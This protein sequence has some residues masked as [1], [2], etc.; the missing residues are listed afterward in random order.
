VVLDRDLNA[1]LNMLRVGQH[2]LAS[3]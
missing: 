1:S 2:A 3:A